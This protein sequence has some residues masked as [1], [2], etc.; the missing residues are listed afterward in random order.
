MSLPDP[1][2]DGLREIGSLATAKVSAPPSTG[3]ALA[4]DAGVDVPAHA[5][6]ASAAASAAAT[7]RMTLRSDMVGAPR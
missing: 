5:D 4:V 6:R 1:M 3:W 2:P 7:G